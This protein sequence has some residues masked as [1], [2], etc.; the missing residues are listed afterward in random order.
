MQQIGLQCNSSS[1][2]VLGL[3]R[4][5]LPFSSIFKADIVTFEAGETMFEPTMDHWTPVVHP[6]SSTGY[7]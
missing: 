2:K 7:S 3:Q 4:V 1:Y 5:I 6:L